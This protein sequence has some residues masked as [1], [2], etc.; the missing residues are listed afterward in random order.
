V[1]GHLTWIE[2]RPASPSRKVLPL[3]RRG[4]LR[5]SNRA[6]TAPPEPPPGRCLLEGRHGSGCTATLAYAGLPGGRT[7]SVPRQAC[8]FFERITFANAC[9]WKGPNFRARR[10]LLI[11][12]LPGRREARA[13]SQVSS[14]ATV[15]RANGR[16]GR[17][18]ERPRKARPL[19]ASQG[20]PGGSANGRNSTSTGR[21]GHGSLLRATIGLGRLVIRPPILARPLHPAPTR[22][23]LGVSLRRPK[24]VNCPARW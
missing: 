1:A 11:P 24:Q 20:L 23:W 13:P 10:M 22:R 12:P 15:A 21:W 14:V 8:A 7:L 2:R 9:C 17:D 5:E 4:T 19:R 18:A 16:A 6:V 3:H